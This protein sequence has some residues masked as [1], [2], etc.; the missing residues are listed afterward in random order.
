METCAKSHFVVPS[1]FPALWLS[2]QRFSMLHRLTF[3]LLIATCALAARSFS[4]DLPADQ[5]EFFEK[6]IRPILSSECYECHGGKKQKGGLS[7]DSRESLRKGGDTG[8]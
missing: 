7:L 8:P 6:K 1:I 3:T 5:V 4:A 2:S